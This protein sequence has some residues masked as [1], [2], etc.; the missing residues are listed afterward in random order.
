MCEEGLKG[1]GCGPE[2]HCYPKSHITVRKPFEMKCLLLGD[3][4]T[5]L[6]KRRIGI[7]LMVPCFLINLNYI[8]DS[9]SNSIE[10]KS[11]CSSFKDLTFLS[12]SS[13]LV[14]FT[15]TNT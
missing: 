6:Y 1:S 8:R 10:M 4:A 12:L 3:T 15:L 5:S 11:Y 14:N 2:G 9:I 13:T 7:W